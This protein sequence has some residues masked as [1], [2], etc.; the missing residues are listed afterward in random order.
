M[1]TI[2]ESVLI[3]KKQPEVSGLEVASFSDQ[4]SGL[5]W[6][7]VNTFYMKEVMSNV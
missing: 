7:H 5:P 3:V 2:F 1:G 4:N 6:I